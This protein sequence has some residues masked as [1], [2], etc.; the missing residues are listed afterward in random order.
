MSNKTLASESSV[1]L[2]RYEQEVN[3]KRNESAGSKKIIFVILPVMFVAL[4][5]M[6]MS[7]GD[8]SGA[9]S[10]A[11]IFPLVIGFVILMLFVALLTGKGKKTDVAKRTRD[12][13][14]ALLLTPEEVHSF[15][16]Q[17]SEAP[18]FE[19]VNDMGDSVFATIDFLG[20]RF[21]V[22]GNVTYTFIRFSEVKS[23]HYAKT[24]GTGIKTAYF[25]DWRD[26]MGKV[27][28]N[29]EIDSG[30]RLEQLTE[31]VRKVKPDV[32]IKKE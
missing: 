30:S 23:L 8:P 15:D 14:D 24:R 21:K 6:L 9:E 10:R 16:A 19:I 32:T 5:F 3:E 27:L 1:W 7:N 18:V 29:G 17:M 2:K 28:M 20:K 4:L 31:A 22:N 25:I 13:L 26:D 11:A 12:N